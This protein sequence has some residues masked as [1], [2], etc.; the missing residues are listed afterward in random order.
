VWRVLGW[1]LPAL[2]GFSAFL[3]AFPID[4]RIP[5]WPHLSLAEVFGV[6]FL[7]VSP[8]TTMV[9]IV[10]F[11]RPRK[12]FPSLRKWL[13]VAAVTVSVLLNLFVLLGLYAAA[14]F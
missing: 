11:A 12:L 9:A 6:W 3:L 2:L 1:C 13:L 7:L 14:A 5:F 4:R 10:M 8:V